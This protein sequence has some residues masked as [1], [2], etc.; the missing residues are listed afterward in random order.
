MSFHFFLKTAVFQ[1]LFYTTK[2][3]DINNIFV[4]YIPVFILDPAT[5]TMFKEA[6]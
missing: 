2:G 4:L 5:Q 6:I 3:V 1:D